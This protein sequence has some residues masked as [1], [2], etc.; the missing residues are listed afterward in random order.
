[1][2]E[3]FLQYIWKYRLYEA[4]DL[5][6]TKG[7]RLEVLDP[8]IQNRDSGPDFFNAKIKMNGTVWAGSVEIHDRA[9]DWR[10]HGHP[11]DAAYG[12]VILHVVLE[13]DMEVERPG[14]HEMIPQMVMVVPDRVV[15]NVEWLLSRDRNLA[16]LERLPAIEPVYR[17]E[18]LDALLSERLERKTQDIFKWL[19]QKQQDWNEAFYILLC[20]NFGFGVNGDAFERLARSL[21]LKCIQKQRNSISQVE[22][23]FLGQ[24]GLLHEEAEGQHHYYRLLQQEYEFL[25]HKYDFLVPL[26][27]HLFRN[28]RLRPNATPHV[29]LVQLAAI[30]SQREHLL[31]A[32]LQARTPREIKDLF[33]VSASDFWD[34]HYN[35]KYPSI[36]RKKSLGENALNILLINSVVPMMFAYGHAHHQPEYSERALKLLERIPAE[37][38]TIVQLFQQAGIEAKHAGDSQAL[39][40]L[41][42][43]YCELK[44]CL[45]CRFGYQLLRKEFNE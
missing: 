11:D 14:M 26:E 23:L 25:R 19:G 42:R 22:A 38:N 24:A 6:T 37:K 28:L 30:F 2:K 18:W 13:D 45:F 10:K 1:M 12:N 4:V 44:K 8:G 21:P 17:T 9:S 32:V 43:N 5:Q 29:K 15:A 36:F 40:Q 16:C 33:R 41:M 3:I 35:F 39:I 34:T 27:P 7:I 31:S 20:R